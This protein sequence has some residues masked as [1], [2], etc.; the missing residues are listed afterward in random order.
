MQ[1]TWQVEF[2]KLKDQE[3][4][5]YQASMEV[6]EKMKKDLI[7]ETAEWTKN[8]DP[9]DCYSEKLTGGNPFQ[10]KK[11]CTN[12]VEYGNAPDLKKFIKCMD[13]NHFCDYCCSYYIGPTNEKDV[14]KCQGKC[15]SIVKS[16]S[17]AYLVQYA[18]KKKG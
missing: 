2:E 15:T 13:R 8:L 18:A 1:E 10:I 4:Q 17:N 9:A 6:R 3:S 5:L 16:D 11:I 7:Q 12:T 14:L